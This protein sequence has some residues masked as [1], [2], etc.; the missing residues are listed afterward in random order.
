MHEN[1]HFSHFGDS[2]VQNFSVRHV[3]SHLHNKRHKEFRQGTLNFLVAFT[4]SC[5][6]K[7]LFMVA[8][9]L[10]VLPYTFA[11]EK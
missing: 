4:V 1:L 11:E 6:M 9:H 2:F 10:S 8:K 3:T 7:T 5:Y